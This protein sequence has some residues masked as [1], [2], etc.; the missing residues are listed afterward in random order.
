ME[1]EQKRRN[2]ADPF[3]LRTVLPFTLPGA[4]R[5]KEFEMKADA[6]AI[7]AAIAAFAESAA[8]V[9]STVEAL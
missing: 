5:N 6:V 9:S 3:Q 2:T 8:T 7:P 4:R 1:P